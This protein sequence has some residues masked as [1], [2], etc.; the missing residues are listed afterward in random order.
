MLGNKGKKKVELFSK[1]MDA[2]LETAGSEDLPP[3][4]PNKIMP[5]SE[6]RNN[7]LTPIDTKKVTKARFKLGKITSLKPLL[8]SLDYSRLPTPLSQ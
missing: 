3:R 4:F 7:T 5:K 1:K 8:E 2:I 6:R